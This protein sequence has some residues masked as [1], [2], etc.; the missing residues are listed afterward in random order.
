MTYRDDAVVAV[1]V[2]LFAHHAAVAP[3][4]RREGVRRA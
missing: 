3:D 1:A 2:F 4:E